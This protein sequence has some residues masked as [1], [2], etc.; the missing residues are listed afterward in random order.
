VI[1]KKSPVIPLTFVVIGIAVACAVNSRLHPVDPKDAAAQNA[2]LQ[3]EQS[4]TQ[5][6]PPSNPSDV[7]GA[8][9]ASVKGEAKGRPMMNKGMHGPGGPG[10][11]G[12]DPMVSRKPEQFRPKP[13]STSTNSQWY[14]NN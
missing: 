11:P 14:T 9:A 6:R 3:Q 2:K 8:L 10:G 12:G 5:M 1:K 13:S 4:Q 7:H